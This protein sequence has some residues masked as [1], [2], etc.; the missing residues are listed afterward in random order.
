MD[1]WLKNHSVKDSMDYTNVWY[2]E[3][4]TYKSGKVDSTNYEDDNG[5]RD[6]KI[7]W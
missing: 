2:K 3:I 5:L 6:G 1:V 7:I 4:N